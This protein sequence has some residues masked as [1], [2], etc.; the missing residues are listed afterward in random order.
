MLPA[1]RGRRQRLARSLCL[2][3]FIESD[4][5]LLYSVNG[6][7]PML[8]WDGQTDQAELAGLAAPTTAPTLSAS[9]KGAI[10]GNYNS[11]VRFVDRLNNYSNLSPV[12]ATLP[13]QA[14]GVGGNV[15]GAT[16]GGP[17]QITTS[18]PH[19]LVTAQMVQ[20]VGVGGMVEANGTF[21]IVVIDNTHFNLTYSIGVNPYTS[22]GRWFP[23]TG[24][25]ISAA[26]A[27][28]PIQ[29]TT[30]AAHGLSTGDVVLLIGGDVNLNFD[31]EWV[32]TVVDSTNFTLNGSIQGNP[33]NGGG[34]WVNG[35]S[36]IMYSNVPTTA[37]PQ[38]VRRQILRNTDGQFSTYYVDIDTTDLTSTSFSSTRTDPFL[39]AQEAAPL[40]DTFLQPLANTR[41]VAPTHKTTLA[42]QL[43]RLFL[44]GQYDETRG[45]VMVTAG[46]AVVTGVGTDWRAGLAGRA[47]YVVGAKNNYQILSVDVANQT[48]TLTADGLVASPYKDVTDNFAMYSIRPF[49]A[50][51]N[52]VYYTPAGQPESWPPSQALAIQ[53]DEDEIIG[54]TARGSFLYIIKKRHIYKLTFQ[55][56]PAKDGAVFLSCN[57][58]CVNNRCWTLVDNDLYMLDEGG[59]HKF[60]SSGQSQK[61]SG[62]ISEI[63]RPGSL[64]KYS[65]N[66]RASR[67]W[68]SVLYR[69]QQT[70]RWFVTMEGDYLPRHALCYDYELS[71]WWIERY[72][73]Q[74]GGACAG[75][76][77]LQPQTFL[78]GESAK[79]Y[80][81]W[82][83]SSDVAQTDQ[84]TVR[85]VPTSVGVNWLSD[86]AAIFSTSGIGSA[87]NAPLTITDGVGK[88]QTRRVVAATATQLTVDMPWTVLPTT[89]STY[90]VGG[91]VWNWKSTWWRLAVAD[92]MA[93]RSIEVLFLTAQHP[94]TMDMRTR[95]DFSTPD[96]QK[97]SITSAQGGGVRSDSGLPDKV[98]DLTK[99]SGVVL[100]RVP[101]T[102]ERFT[103]GRRYLQ[104]EL[105]GVTNKDRES[106][107]EIIVEGMASIANIS[108]Q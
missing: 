46:S 23:V 100:V 5:G 99:A 16:L 53:E 98:V 25:N 108:G 97:L 93:D 57:R 4:A 106:V 9:G 27:A 59:I 64:Y 2:D 80:S 56:D 103:D 74:V 79:T 24:G 62:E 37:D 1:G 17:I 72:P 35:V 29:I 89:K 101:G 91:V 94:C 76:I 63:F 20:I 6:F 95:Q 52:L 71:R 105:A 58:G 31:G 73:F 44:T 68:F 33:Y 55:V 48:L 104:L 78:S 45:S 49:P 66:W 90:Q 54:A 39:S 60:D 15:V 42:S 88:G 92:S 84:G 47:L 87:I 32:I 69:P 19:G 36:T 77:K 22:G 81:M 3:S 75:D 14:T 40:L 70:I 8:R 107:F 86:S 28:T 13:A 34:T 10:V 38:V 85:G 83:G 82:S 30:T 21:V 43:G 11:Y 96:V 65:L 12:S 61:I 7:D 67:Y 26:S 51:R 102:R 50:E 18:A 41:Y